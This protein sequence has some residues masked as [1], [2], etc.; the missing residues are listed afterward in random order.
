MERH[1]EFLI[2]GETH[3]IPSDRFYG[4]ENHMWA[5]YDPSKRQV[6]VGMDE[7][8]ITAL[9]DL[10]YVTLLPVGAQVERGKSI[11]KLEA[12]KMTG[13]L[14]SPVSGV[15]VARNEKAVQNPG[16][17][18]QDAYQAGWLVVI[19]PTHWAEESARLV[20]GD[21]LPDWVEDEVERYRQQGW[22][23]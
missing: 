3:S 7:L 21:A 20:S 18:N 9:G 6:I 15:I 22:L 11:G 17:I 13:D 12:A 5:Q 4:R 16:L 14:S 8:G 19:Q 23:D 2:S 1:N 10:A